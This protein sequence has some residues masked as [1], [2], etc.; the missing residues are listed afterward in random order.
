MLEAR[1]RLGGRVHTL[2]LRARASTP[3]SEASTSTSRHTAVI[4]SVR[5]HGL[6]LEDVR[7]GWAGLDELVYRRRAANV[8][9]D[10]VR[11]DGANARQIGRFWSRAVLACSTRSRSSEPGTRSRARARPHLDRGVRSTGSAVSGRARFLLEARFRGDYGVEPR[12]LSAALRRCSPRR[13]PGTSPAPGSR[14]SGFAAATARLGGGDPPRGSSGRVKTGAAVVAI[15]QGMPRGSAP[16]S[17]D[18]ATAE[19]DHC[20][21]AVPLPALRRIDFRPALAGAA[22]RS[23]SRRSGYATVGARPIFDCGRRFWRERGFSGDVLS[24]LRAGLRPGRRPTS[25][26][27]AAER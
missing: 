2:R 12:E 7:R 26:P 20:V 14:R 8:P 23:G 6:E 4:E 25:S 11:G 16:A 3:R 1:D 17:A 9:L 22:R 13:S 27:G 18:G 21:L 19:A 5:R 24:D 10:R 15:E